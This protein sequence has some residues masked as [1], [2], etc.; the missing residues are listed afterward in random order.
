MRDTLNGVNLIQLQTRATVVPPIRF[1]RREIFP[2]CV[3]EALQNE[4]P[5]YFSGPLGLN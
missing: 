2:E 5:G 3:M 1:G 4:L